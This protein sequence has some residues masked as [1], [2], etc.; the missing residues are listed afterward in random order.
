[1]RK[2]IRT[3]LYIPCI[4]FL[5]ISIFHYHN[6]TT[7]PVEA[8]F[9]NE[10][11]SIILSTNPSHPGPLSPVT[12]RAQSGTIDTNRAFFTWFINQKKV[13]EGNG[14]NEIRTTTG[15]EGVNKNIKVIATLSSGQTI[16]E[17]MNISSDFVDL[18][19]ESEGYS[20]PFYQGRT[21]L[22]P[23]TLGK[24][25]A[26]PYVYTRAGTLINPNDLYYTWTFNNNVMTSR[27]GLGRNIFYNDLSPR[28]NAI[29]VQVSDSTGAIRATS[30][31][32]VN[33]ETPEIL[34]YQDHPIFGVLYTSS[35][36]ES[37]QLRTPEI[38]L[39]AEPLG[40]SVT[41]IF[42]NDL[43]INWNVNKQQTESP[44]KNKIGISALPGTS[45]TISVSAS[46]D[47]ALYQRAITNIQLRF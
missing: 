39:K 40:F 15:N 35:L 29:S 6:T 8:Q 18:I 3:A 45:G 27:S 37:I 42:E 47:K 25:V 21:P 20:Q 22:L 23:H 32:N 33:R 43:R 16:T 24:I 34:V 9:F 7:Q 19:W 17:E 30:Y 41:N 13:A 28:N 26:L 46:H 12:I 10:N 5:Y 11:Q 31:I 38:V 14:I 1:M 4:L 44:E 36:F 2:S